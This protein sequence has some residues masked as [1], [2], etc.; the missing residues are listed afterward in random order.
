MPSLK[1]FLENLFAIAK[2]EETDAQFQNTLR[3]MSA[4]DI[5][6]ITRL[7]RRGM[8]KFLKHHVCTGAWNG[9]PVWRRLPSFYETKY[10]PA[11]CRAMG[12]K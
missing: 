3:G 1:E 2:G 5:E 7:R 10:T 12:K 8:A 9:S 11:L 6:R 4:F